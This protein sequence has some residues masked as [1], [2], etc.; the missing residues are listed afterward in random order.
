MTDHM[1]QLAIFSGTCLV[2]DIC[3]W[4]SQWTEPSILNQ[5]VLLL[6]LQ[7]ALHQYQQEKKDTIMQAISQIPNGLSDKKMLEVVQHL[8]TQHGQFSHEVK[9]RPL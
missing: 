7:H 5:D 2:A 8:I 9:A 1:R 3:F 6:N 4:T